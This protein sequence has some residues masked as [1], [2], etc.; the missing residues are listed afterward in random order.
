MSAMPLHS[1]PF[2]AGCPDQTV[3]LRRGFYLFEA[4]GASGG[5]IGGGNGSYTAGYIRLYNSISFTII[6]GGQGEEPISGPNRPKGGCNGG[7]DGGAG[8]YYAAESHYYYSGSGG[9]GSTDILLNDENGEENRILVSGGGGGSAGINHSLGGAAG[10]IYGLD[11]KKNTISKG[12]NQTGFRK[13]QG[14]HGRD[15]TDIAGGGEGNGGGGGGWFGGYSSH[16]TGERSDAGGGGGSSYISGHSQCD[17]HPSLKFLKTIM[18]TG[19]NSF[20]SPE[21]ITEIGHKGNGFVRIS[22]F[23]FKTCQQHHFSFFFNLVLIFL[24][25]SK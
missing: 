22:V 19:E 9:G 3:T 2:I 8:A 24:L 25:T 7:G 4:W 12:A 18:K 11:S 6:V 5:G 17:P 20:L 14:Q 10:G 1:F 13:G 16:S 21:G 23:S 15:G